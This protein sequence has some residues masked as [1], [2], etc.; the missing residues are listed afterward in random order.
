[1][2]LSFV[3]TWRLLFS[4]ARVFRSD[5]LMYVR[6]LLLAATVDLVWSFFFSFLES[7][8]FAISKHSER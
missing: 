3:P 1:M 5:T 8:D 7:G 6:L 4:L 2:C